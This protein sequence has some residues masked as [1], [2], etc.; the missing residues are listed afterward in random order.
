MLK[1]V[2]EERLKLHNQRHLGALQ[3]CNVKA[4]YTRSEQVY[5]DGL[6]LGKDLEQ[7]P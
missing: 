1:D 2:E 4:L 3:K 5:L 7:L 6:F